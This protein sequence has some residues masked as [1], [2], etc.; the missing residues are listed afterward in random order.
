MNSRVSKVLNHPLFKS[1]LIYTLTDAINKGIPFLLLPVLTYY[2]SPSDYG[3]ISNFTVIISILGILVG[4]S[5]DGAISA[6]FY[7]L[8]K[9]KLAIYISNT[10][11][12]TICSFLICIIFISLFQTQVYELIKIPYTY[13]VAAVFMALG[14]AI[15]AINL[16]LWR[17]EEKP[18][19]FG[20]Y[21]ISQTLIN[22]SFSLYFIII[23]SLG[24]QG[25]VDGYLIASFSYGIFS[26]LIL[27][28]RGYLKLSYR[29]KFLMD[30]L[31]FGIPLIPHGL[32][33]WIRS[34]IDRVFITKL[35]DEAATGI[36][37]TGFQF[38]I[39][40]SFLTLAFN[41]AFVPFLFKQLSV[42]D[43]V[44]L[45]LNK[46]RLVK[47]TYLIM[48][49]LIILC[50]FFTFFSI[51]LVDNLL[52]ESYY[53][54]RKFVFWAI[55]AQAFQGMYLLFVNYIFYVKRTKSLALITFTCSLIHVFLAYGLINYIGAIGA[56]YSMVI[57]S[58][59]NF[60]AVWVYSAKV[61]P[62]PWFRF[63]KP[64]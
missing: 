14:Q 63:N 34:G 35:I 27:R 13:Q 8:D 47:L 30:A 19:K 45:A 4:L 10:L 20:L 56:A 21:Q 15:T 16:A 42:N 2:L 61:Y 33:I 24:W 22:I 26:L 53:A 28:K 57:V 3:I 12:I 46:K 1:G 40:M 31:F 54:S 43:T 29:K 11:I 5:L 18:L 38:G 55:L 41:N 39:F 60:V 49:G 32:S 23:L 17:L 59:I 62:M 6:N 52:S 58:F 50:I 51:L 7:R 36:Y 48:G 44:Q 9:P 37:S 25:R 64:I